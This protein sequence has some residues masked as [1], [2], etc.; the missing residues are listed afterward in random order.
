[1]TARLAER[2]R[3]ERKRQRHVGVD[4]DHLDTREARFQLDLTLE[5]TPSAVADCASRLLLL[6][7]LLPSHLRPATAVLP[8][9]AYLPRPAA[10]LPLSPLVL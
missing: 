9:S 4:D 1:M 8:S 7:L 10:A 3:L 2:K 6:L 5:T